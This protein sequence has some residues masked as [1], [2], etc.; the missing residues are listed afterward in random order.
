MGFAF[1]FRG[2]SHIHH[3]SFWLSSPSVGSFARD[4]VTKPSLLEAHFNVNRA[5]YSGYGKLFWLYLPI[6]RL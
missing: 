3:A 6:S 4:E 2:T 1:E 5:D